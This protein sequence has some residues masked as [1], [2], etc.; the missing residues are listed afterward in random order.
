[1]Q[2]QGDPYRRARVGDP[3]RARRRA[4]GAGEIRSRCAQA[5]SGSDSFFRNGT[6]CSGMRGTRRTAR[7]TRGQSVAYVAGVVGSGFGRRFGRCGHVGRQPNP[8]VF[9]DLGPAGPRQ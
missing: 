3:A 8:S 4:D 7:S 5:A 1:M 6:D 2:H 9:V